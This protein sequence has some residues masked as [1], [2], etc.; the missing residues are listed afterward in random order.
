ME[1]EAIVA[2]YA[3]WG[4]GAKGTQPVVLR[5]DRRHFRELTEG[6][7]VIVGRRTLADFPGGKPL[8]GRRN[9]VVTRQDLSIEGA[10]VVHSVE[11]ALAAV[12]GERC[13]VI[14][15]ASVYRDF[16]P[17]LSRIFVTKIDLAP[18]SDSFFPDLDADE[19][20][21][22]AEQG[23]WAEENGVRYCFCVYEK[24]AAHGA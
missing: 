13:L 23:P 7:A 14:G 12:A 3:D 22:C 4:I 9:L 18:H 11:E 21:V 24:E 15:G 1:L 20:W 17:H 5:A 8:R 2:V 19:V 10:E 16:F 6:A